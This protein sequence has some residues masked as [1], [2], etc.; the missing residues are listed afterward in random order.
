MLKN[1]PKTL[2]FKTPKNKYRVFQKPRL[3]MLSE[4]KEVGSWENTQPLYFYPFSWLDFLNKAGTRELYV[5]DCSKSIAKKEI[6]S[7]KSGK[8]H[9]EKV[10]IEL[11]NFAKE[12]GHKVSAICN[13]E[14]LS[15]EDI[16]TLSNAD[17]VKI[18]VKDYEKMSKLAGLPNKNVLSCIKAY[19]GDSCNYRNIALQSKEM[20]FDFFHVSKKLKCSENQKISKNEKEMIS[21]LKSLESNRFKIIIPSSLEE[22]FAK[23]FSINA[24]YGNTSLCLFSKYRL[25]LGKGGYYPCYT[26][27]IL[28]SSGSKNKSADKPRLCSDCACIYENDMLADIESK[29]ANHENTCFA[30]EY[31]K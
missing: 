20:G 13:L 4:G 9:F 30:L 5:D 22:R 7:L 11:I 15:Q 28:H 12:R 19:I 25:V 17:F 10:D 27:K 3:V 1:N 26:Q 31:T 29:M 21:A 14:D 2:F 24:D 6:K 8:V 23:K 16:K 18:R